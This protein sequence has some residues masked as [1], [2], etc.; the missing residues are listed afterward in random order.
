VHRIG[1]L[2]LLNRR[3]NSGARNWE[4][5]K[6]KEKYFSG[7]S[8]TSPFAITTEV[9]S[10]AEWKPAHFKERQERFLNRL[11]HEWRLG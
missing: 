3:Q 10:K 6:K 5:D 1:N 11:K 9:L 2:A 7:R 4:L 8:G